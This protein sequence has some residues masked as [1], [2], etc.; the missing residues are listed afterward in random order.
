[1]AVP[2]FPSQTDAHRNGQTTQS[3]TTQPNVNPQPLQRV[4]TGT[5]VA[6][7]ET[8]GAKLKKLFAPP[9]IK[10]IALSALEHT[11]IPIAKKA[12]AVKHK[13]DVPLA[14]EFVN[15]LYGISTLQFPNHEGEP[16]PG[17]IES[18]GDENVKDESRYIFVTVSTDHVSPQFMPE[19]AKLIAILTDTDRDIHVN[20]I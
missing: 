6:K 19:I 18:T 15:G 8:T 9:D 11:I 12:I 17:A 3:A 7:K 10:A 14:K 16:D 5:V 4:T 13:I 1:M 2:S 20:V